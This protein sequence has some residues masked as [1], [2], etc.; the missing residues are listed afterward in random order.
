MRRIALV[1][2]VVTALSALGQTSRLIPAFPG[3]EGHGRY[4]QGGRGGKIVHVTN[5]NDAGEGSLREAVMGDEPKIVVFDV[6]GVIA[7]ESYLFIGENTTIAGQTAPYPGITLRYFTVR[8]RS[9]NVVRFIR[10]RLGAERLTKENDAIYQ[11]RVSALLLDHCSF[12]WG[13]DET[14]TFYN[15]NNF[16]MQWCSVSEALTNSIHGKGSHG[17]GGIWGGKLASFHH[18]MIAHVDNRAPRFAGVSNELWDGYIYNRLY[19]TYRWENTIQA[20]NVDYRNCVVY[21]W[22]VKNG[23]YGG[24]DGGY[25]NMVNNYYKAGPATLFTTRLTQVSPGS[26]TNTASRYYIHGNY[27][28]AAG[29]EASF[30][31]WKGVDFDNPTYLIDDEW[32]TADPDSMYG[33]NVEHKLNE[34]GTPCVRI[35]IDEP[36]PTGEVTTHAAETAYEKVLSYVG[37]SLFRDEVDQRNVLEAREG[38]ATYTGSI[39]GLPGIIDDVADV[40]GYT[41][42]NFPT[43]QRPEGFDTDRDGMPDAWETA[44]GLDPKNAD[45]GQQYTIDPLGFYSNVEVYLNSLVQDIMLTGNADAEQSVDE[46][47][48]AYFKED[49]TRVEAVNM[50]SEEGEYTLSLN[51]A[52]VQSTDGYFTFGTPFDE[53]TGQGNKFNFNAK[54]VGTYGDV[55][56][57]KGLKMEGSTVIE[58][59]STKPATVTI[60]QSTWNND[61]IKTIKFDNNEL[62]IESATHDEANGYYEYVVKN[63]PVGGHTITR[64]NGESG[65]F[66]IKLT[67]QTAGSSDYSFDKHNAFGWGTC[68]DINGTPY[69]LDG[70]WHKE[71]PTYTVLYASGG[72]DR[73][74]IMEAIE[75][76]DIVVLDGSQG[77]FVLSEKMLLENIKHKSI[78][79]RNNARLCTQWY[80]TPELRQA[81]NNANVNQYRPDAGTG[82]YL[83]NGIWVDEAREQHTR[84]VVID[85]TGDETEI[86]RKAGFF[87]FNSSDENIIIRNLTFVGPGSVDVGGAD[88]VSNYGATN[89]WIDHCDFIDG[90]DGN[91]DSGQRESSDMFSTYSWNIFRYTDRSYSHSNSNLTTKAKGFHQY[92]TYAYNIW[93]E[94]CYSRMPRIEGSDVHLLNN[95]YNCPNNS[96]GIAIASSSRDLVEGNYAVDGVKKPFSAGNKDA[97]VYW[98]TR[99]NIGFGDYNNATNT[100]LSLEVPYPYVCFPTADVPVLL[101][102]SNGAGPTLS[103]DDIVLPDGEPGTMQKTVFAIKEGDTFKSGQII[104]LE[105]IVLT[106]GEQ[107]GADFLA[108]QTQALDDI[109]TAYTP[110]NDVNGNKP[111]GTFYVFAPQKDG[112]LTV[113][114]KHNSGKP[115]YVEEDGSALPNFNGITNDE[116][117]YY[118]FSFPVKAGS[119]YKLYCTGSK[120]GFYG[121]SFKWV[122]VETG[123]RVFFERG[124]PA[125]NTY[126]NLA[127]QRLSK[128][129]KGIN[130]IGGRKVVV[131]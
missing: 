31:D 27:V 48:P 113:A 98:L 77:D 100:E 81:L 16:T 60:V 14:A 94:G 61:G 47:Y 96:A 21:N 26:R 122:N 36:I 56:Y 5:L 102:G 93:D 55:A 115:L 46:Y 42:Q 33:K 1:L 53:S 91:L 74:A 10:S 118:T 120:L 15:N 92:V 116:T 85:F 99:N 105:G 109:F 82:G 29:E 49:G 28:A 117:K 58:W 107:G 62:S 52:A 119:I 75:T 65:L 76:F 106:F 22:G 12:S 108:A 114:V 43:G 103:Y 11:Y 25:I 51:G 35:R 73:Q 111:G 78:L 24:Q 89:V 129:Q 57:T 84:Q 121:F 13:I 123:I 34:E 54:F 88:L 64:G 6:A 63:V 126:Y 44:N 59:L 71:N 7:L 17:Y 4:T 125:N 124:K 23:C 127:G 69:Q 67:Y 39:T 87:V 112:T 90:M 130:I 68:S 38:T 72:D 30:Y 41:E 97:Q 101:T 110:G 86:Y 79:G 128:P 37:S 2:F 104:E 95:Y 80:I 70:G 19:N 45:D 18:N 32:Y 83:S 20:E 40:N 3:A 50:P 8:P 9:N 66:F 131:K